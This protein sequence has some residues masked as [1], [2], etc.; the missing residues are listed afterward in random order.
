MA[1][2]NEKTW[3]QMQLRRLEYLYGQQVRAWEGKYTDDRGVLCLTYRAMEAALRSLPAEPIKY[4]QVA[5]NEKMR[6]D[7][8]RMVEE[9]MRKI[10]EI[11]VE[12]DGESGG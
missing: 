10:G 5:M 3:W 12:K 6:E 1:Y 9:S 8:K 11:R 4:V 7:R 2:V